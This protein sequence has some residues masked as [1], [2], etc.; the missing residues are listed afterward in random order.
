[1]QGR[2]SSPSIKALI[3]AVRHTLTGRL[4]NKESEGDPNGGVG[5]DVVT[6]IAV[7]VDIREVRGVA[8]DGRQKPPVGAQN[9]YSRRPMLILILFRGKHLISFT[10][11]FK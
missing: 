1:M 4:S 2:L 10:P 6:G 5:R 8:A 3:S 9:Y 7:V 11:R